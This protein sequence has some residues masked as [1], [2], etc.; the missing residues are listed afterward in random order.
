MANRRGR[1][2]KYERRMSVNERKADSR[3][4]KAGKPPPKLKDLPK[5]RD[6][7]RWPRLKVTVSV[8]VEDKGELDR[9]NIFRT[10][11]HPP[12]MF[13]A[14]WERIESFVGTLPNE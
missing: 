10:D 4:I 8:V 2:T 9:H 5:K 11:H 13:P 1:P 14:L 3:A 12:A 6:W 7:S